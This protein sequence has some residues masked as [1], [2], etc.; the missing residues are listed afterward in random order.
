MIITWDNNVPVYV[1][2]N[3][4]ITAWGQPQGVSIN[5]MEYLWTVGMRPT[6]IVLTVRSADWTNR[7]REIDWLAPMH[8]IEFSRSTPSRRYTQPSRIKNIWPAEGGGMIWLSEARPT[9][10]T[11]EE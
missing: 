5:I 3:Q 1:S 10:Y 6:S 8:E 2:G 7:N 4:A 11:V 9:D